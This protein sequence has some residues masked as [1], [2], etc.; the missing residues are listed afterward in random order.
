MSKTI[1]DL[2]RLNPV[3][4]YALRK[5]LPLPETGTDPLL[6]YGVELEIE[7]LSEERRSYMVPGTT[8]H[9]DGSLRNNGGEYVTHPCKMRELEYVL[10]NFFARGQFN[11]NNYSERCST[12]VHV[13][14][15]DF[16][17]DMIMSLVLLYQLFERVLFSYVGHGRDKNIFC[18]PWYD[19]MLVNILDKQ[20]LNQFLSAAGGWQKYTSL[21][22]LPM[23]T[24]GTVEFR[25]M[26][27]THDMGRI[28]QWCNIIGCMTSYARKTSHEQLKQE[29]KTLNSSSRYAAFLQEVFREYSDVL[30]TSCGFEQ[31]M[32][33]GVIHCKRA[34][35]QVF[36]GK[37]ETPKKAITSYAEWMERHHRQQEAV[38]TDNRVEDG[39]VG[40]NEAPDPTPRQPTRTI[41]NPI[42]PVRRQ[43]LDPNA[44]W[45][46][47]QRMMTADEILAFL[48]NPQPPVQGV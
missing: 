17:Y 46:I 45:P 13:N 26:H 23:S 32:E 35:V 43:D 25:H 15:Q 2:Y 6:V 37:K 9:E 27:G 8:Y 33:E 21:N 39:L 31:A 5:L 44:Q 11:E 16:T 1:L 42:R 36:E 18:V 30:R 41:R 38:I 3:Q 12:H 20:D 19:T 48:N 40:A 28:L 10:T 7:N 24:Q 29:I 4:P 22:L 34:L 47:P 14:V